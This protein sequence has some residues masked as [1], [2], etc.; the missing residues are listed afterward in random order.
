MAI[1]R[2]RRALDEFLVLGVQ[3]TIPFHRWLFEQPD[4]RAGRMDTGFVEREWLAHP[5]A[6][7]EE[8][9][10]RAA[11]LAALAAHRRRPSPPAGDGATGSPAP[12]RWADAGRRAALRGG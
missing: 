12:S 6:P 8:L 10:E 9:A 1:R 5:P 3:T 7:D 2:M 11:V 4:F